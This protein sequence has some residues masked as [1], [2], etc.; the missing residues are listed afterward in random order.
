MPTAR[1]YGWP[2]EMPLRPAAITVNQP[3]TMAADKSLTA[4]AVGTI[5]LPNATSDLA[6]SGTGIKVGVLNSLSGTMAI[7][8][9]GFR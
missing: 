1:S 5:S 2:G 9:E 6:T 8:G 4:N 3:I 7:S